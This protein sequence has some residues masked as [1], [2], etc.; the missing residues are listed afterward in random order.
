MQDNSDLGI[1]G[2]MCRM[3]IAQSVP[4]FEKV[5]EERR[6]TPRPTHAAGMPSSLVEHRR[7]SGARSVRWLRVRD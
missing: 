2:P 3:G 5:S 1:R 7:E 6:S 4:A